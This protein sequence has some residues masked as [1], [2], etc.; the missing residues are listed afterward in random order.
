MLN[1]PENKELS[2]FQ[3]IAFNQKN[4]NFLR[5]PTEQ[6]ISFSTALKW[7]IFEK[8]VLFECCGPDR[9]WNW[10]SRFP[11]R[12]GSRFGPKSRPRKPL[13]IKSQRQKG[14][15]YVD[16]AF[17]IE[18]GHFELTKRFFS[19][20]SGGKRSG[21]NF[22]PK[23]KKNFFREFFEPIYFWRIVGNSSKINSLV[24]SVRKMT[25]FDRILT[26]E[27]YSFSQPPSEQMEQ[28]IL[29]SMSSIIEAIERKKRLLSID[30]NYCR[31]LTTCLRKHLSEI[32]DRIRVFL[33]ILKII[34]DRENK[35][36]FLL[37]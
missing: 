33:S 4:H 12:C 2:C 16:L 15:N 21:K 26:F 8:R 20:T 35:S 1:L 7:T 31:Y 32:K 23:L 5:F 22:R 27:F 10:C 11:V 36:I 6:Q 13:D 24:S 3:R 28:R 30:S 9:K 19:R 14:G 17:D 29:Q 25:I 34:L 37:I 18:K